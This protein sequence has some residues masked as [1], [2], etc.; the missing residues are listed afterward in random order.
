MRRRWR[1]ATYMV[2]AGVVLGGVQRRRRRR[3]ADHDRV[4]RDVDRARGARR[5]RP[6]HQPRSA[7]PTSTAA[8]NEHA[9]D[10]CA[11]PLRRRRRRP[12][13]SPIR[14]S[15]GPPPVV[16]STEGCC[17]GAHAAVR[18]WRSRS[19]REA[20]GDRVRE[21]QQMLTTLGFDVGE[22]RS[23]RPSSGPTARPRSGSG[24]RSRAMPVDRHRLHGG[25]VRDGV[26]H[27]RRRH[28]DQRRRLILRPTDRRGR[29]PR[30]ARAGTPRTGRR[31]RR[32]AA[33]PPRP[34]G[35]TRSRASA[36]SA[37]SC[38]VVG[39]QPRRAARASDRSACCTSTVS[40]T[41]STWARCCT[42]AADGER[43]LGRGRGSGERRRAAR[44]S[45]R[46]PAPCRRG[47]RRSAR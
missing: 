24:R 43:V 22:L 4:R 31:C 32:P 29:A 11:A 10:R 26:R 20:T 30:A 5:R 33:A 15:S 1:A 45:A 35:R 7:R 16:E 39:D 44:S 41:P 12:R 42:R 23:R 28:G 38:V 3:G 25:L 8:A 47:G 9:V 13:S 2:M 17:D 40:G 46:R 36:R 18:R 21:L 37:R 14:A 34:A 6:I 19:P 27:R